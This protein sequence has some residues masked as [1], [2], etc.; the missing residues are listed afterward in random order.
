MRINVSIAGERGDVIPVELTPDDEHPKGWTVTL[1]KTGKDIGRVYKDS[2]TYSP[3]V[4]RG[5]RIARE[6][7]QVS[8][9]GGVVAR[10]RPGIRR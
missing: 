6:H 5:S 8:S 3:P 1:L 10:P 4:H 9:W 7:R 2:Y